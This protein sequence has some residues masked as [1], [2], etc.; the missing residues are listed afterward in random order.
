[1]GEAKG[2]PFTTRCPR[3]QI[4]LLLD[5][6][7]EKWAIEIK[8]SSE[9]SPD[10]FARLAKTAEMVNATKEVLISHTADAVFSEYR[11]SASL[12]DFLEYLREARLDI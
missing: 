6:G 1:M 8:L 12:A 2:A 3:R 5:F 10:D 7:R 9:P 4:D 11:V